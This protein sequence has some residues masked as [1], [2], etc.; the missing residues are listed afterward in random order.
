MSEDVLSI[1]VA[2][3]VVEPEHTDPWLRRFG[4]P[5][6]SWCVVR[7]PDAAEEPG[8]AADEPPG[9]ELETVIHAWLGRARGAD[10]E[11]VARVSGP[12]H[13]VVRSADRLFRGDG[14]TSAVAMAVDRTP[15]SVTLAAVVEA[16]DL[17]LLVRR[18]WHHRITLALLRVRGASGAEVVAALDRG[19]DGQALAWADR[20]VVCQSSVRRCS[21][22]A[23]EPAALHGI[24]GRAPAY[25]LVPV[26]PLPT[27]APVRRARRLS[28]PDARLRIAIGLGAGLVAAGATL[29]VSA[30]LR[31]GPPA[32]EPLPAS[33]I[34]AIEASP[35]AAATEAGTASSSASPTAAIPTPPP[36]PFV[37]A[38]VQLAAS[39]PQRS[40]EAVAFDAAHD[41]VVL[42]GGGNSTSRALGDTWLFRGGTWTQA[43]PRSSPPAR[44]GAAMAFNPG[45]GH[46]VLVGGTSASARGLDDTWIWDGTTWTAVASRTRPPPGPPVA[47]AF[48]E[49]GGTMVLLTRGTA[50]G[51]A[52]T[53]WVF[54]GGAWNAQPDSAATTASPG[55][56]VVDDPA[57]GR[58]VL[59]DA[60]AGVTRVWNGVAWSDLPR[61]ATPANAAAV[62][63]YDATARQLVLFA[64]TPGQPSSTWTFDGTAWSEAVSAMSPATVGALASTATQV[65]AFGG[66][67]VAQDLSQAWR[68]SASGWG[69]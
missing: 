22:G 60:A 37:P 62:V 50:S 40:G 6:M 44:S 27:T 51:N 18:A 5:T 57:L 45:T 20:V 48:D 26:T 64:S 14:L 12:Y 34:A 66:P 38:A 47:L 46:V 43:H 65:V 17:H 69:A 54:S 35:S 63:A 56:S 15:A 36:T 16:R 28:W 23:S 49:V 33:G 19:D 2:S 59:V 52:V 30:A 32:P 10:A 21:L 53:T 11:W 61:A 8:D 4:P 68:W 3:L 9:G 55:A 29:L 67:S 39:P 7:E 24:V 42:F 41:T 31:P 1:G 58:P 25:S 13:D